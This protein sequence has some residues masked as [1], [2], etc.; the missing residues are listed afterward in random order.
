MHLE[1]ELKTCNICLKEKTIP[2]FTHL[3][4]RPRNYCKNCI[5]ERNGEW[6]RK[7]PERAKL[8]AKKYYEKNKEKKR[9][10]AQKYRKENPELSRLA[11]KKYKEKN[12][13]EVLR[14]FREYNARRSQLPEYKEK[15]KKWNRER[16]YRDVEKSR[17]YYREKNA[18]RK[19][20]I[21]ATNR[22]QKLK[23]KNVKTFQVTKAEL[24]KI[25]S[26]DCC[27]CGKTGPSTIDHIIPVSRG[28]V[29]SIGNL[30]P[31]CKSCN[32]RKS[33]RVMT[34]WRLDKSANLVR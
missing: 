34:E 5:S 9:L 8:I 4:G 15:V 21:S 7:N 25:T 14:K 2:E 31:L 19:E 29:H 16:Y 20:A 3:K 28:G 6:R 23:R 30:Q 18:Q 32:S 12:R 26:S 27:N 33:N 22:E 1:G 13:E 10:A 11:V 24:H 17:A